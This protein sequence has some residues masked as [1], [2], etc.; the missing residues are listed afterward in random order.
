[1]RNLS[2]LL[3]AATLAVALPAAAQTYPSKP[4]RIVVVSTPGGSV[5][6][7]A[8]AIAPRLSSKWSQ[9]VLVDNRP[10]AGGAIAAE[11]VSKAPPDGYT[12]MM[13]TIASLATNVSLYKSLPYDPLKDFAPITLVATQNLVLLVHPSIPSRSVKELVALAKKQPGKL[14]FASAGN[15][16]GGHLSGELFKMLAQIDILHIPYK[17]VQPAMMDVVGGQVTMVF[18]SIASGMAQVAN[19]R[20][21]P[22]AVTGAQRSPAARELPTM[23]EAG[24]KGYESSTWYGLVAPAG[25]PSDIVN[26]L[27][28]E[29]VAGLKSPDLNER[30]TREGADP[31]G[32]SP[33]EF[34]KYMQSEIDKWRK[35]IRAAGIQPS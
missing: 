2:A 22:L 10:G 9:Q 13:G 3:I 14:T 35:V 6:T 34:S 7:L 17:G 24:I 26:R 18:A 16:V 30:L 12:L 19:K 4:V 1:M 11:L 28:A 23:V 8:R 15:G 25:T 27:N 21:F 33:A 5:D 20:L 29:V 31:V 32:N